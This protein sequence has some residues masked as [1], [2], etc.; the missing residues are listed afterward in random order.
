MCDGGGVSVSFSSFLFDGPNDDN[1]DDDDDG[2]GGQGLK[3]DFQGLRG[4]KTDPGEC[5]LARSFP[6]SLRV[7][8][9]FLLVP[10]VCLCAPQAPRF[11]GSMGMSD[12]NED[13]DVRRR[14]VHAS[15]AN[16]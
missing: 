15:L 9:S 8:G 10:R 13:I 11:S 7:A 16:S 3:H 6:R 12:M 5:G 2:G 4:G 1:D 14:E